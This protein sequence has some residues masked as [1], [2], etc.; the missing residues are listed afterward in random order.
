MRRRTRFCSP[1]LEVVL[2]A[3]EV[4]GVGAEVLLAELNDGVGPAAG[5][6][7][8]EADG[9]HGPETERVAPTAGGLL[10]REA[11]FEVVHLLGIC[12]SRNGR[13]S[14]CGVG[15]VPGIAVF[16]KFFPGFLPDVLG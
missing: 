11:A 8:G 12:I 5:F 16:G 9:L 1:Y 10:N 4:V 2:E 3:D 14:R 15:E 6:G 7:I 13:G